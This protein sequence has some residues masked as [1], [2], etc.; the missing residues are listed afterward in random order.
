MSTVNIVL[1]IVLSAI[2]GFAMGSA[3]GQAK[4]KLI[5]NQMLDKLT[6]HL[7]GLKD[8]KDKGGSD[9]NE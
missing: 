6:L 5:F 1:M 4:M 2:I 3:Y 8:S 9:T 7:K